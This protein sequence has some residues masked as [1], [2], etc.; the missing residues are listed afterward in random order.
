MTLDYANVL[1]QTLSDEIALIAIYIKNHLLHSIFT[2]IEL[3]YNILLGSQPLTKY[4]YL[5]WAK[6]DVHIPKDK[7]IRISNLS[8]RGIKCD[9]LGYMKSTKIL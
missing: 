1:P 4:L 8:L 3:V 2:L 6:C 7:Q 9:I 5:F